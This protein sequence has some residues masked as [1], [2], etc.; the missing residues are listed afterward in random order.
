[1]TTCRF[2][3]PAVLLAALIPGLPAC[4]VEEDE[5]EVSVEPECTDDPELGIIY[6]SRDEGCAAEETICPEGDEP[7]RDDCG[8]GC[9]WVGECV[10]GQTR[11]VDCNECTCAGGTWSCTLIECGECSP[12]ETRDDLESC[13]ECDCVDGAWSCAAI[14]GCCT[15]GDRTD[16]PETCRSCACV[17]GMWSCTTDA[18]CELAACLSACDDCDGLDPETAV[19]GADGELYCSTC[20]L[21]CRGVAEAED[22][23]ACVECDEGTIETIDCGVRNCVRGRWFENLDEWC[24]HE[25]CLDACPSDCLPEDE[26]PCG[27]DLRYHCTG[28]HMACNEVSPAEDAAVCED[29]ASVCEVEPPPDSVPVSWSLFALG[30][31]CSVPWEIW[32]DAVFTSDE[33]LADAYGCTEP[34]GIDWGAN[35]LARVVFPERTEAEVL[36]VWERSSEMFVQLAAA[37]YCG[38]AA[39]PD[40]VLHV[41]I[42]ASG[43]EELRSNPCT[44]GRCVGP[45][46]P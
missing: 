19:C 21:E 16:D 23:A 32:G 24:L 1:M 9:R 27:D 2:A 20:E 14:P 8:C 15:E 42:P 37:A 30:S 39:P 35:R 36:G 12:G 34:S 29:P 22:P 28:C 5:P 45:P 46:A 26:R 11:T 4:E 18:A 40:V 6:V 38:G 10:D 7:F 3:F 17:D 43:P 44:Y 25:R 31:D 33:G 41:L 13:T